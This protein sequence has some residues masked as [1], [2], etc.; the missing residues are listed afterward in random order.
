MVDFGPDEAVVVVAA[1][2]SFAAGC[3]VVVV[4]ADGGDFVVAAEEV[5]SAIDELLAGVAVHFEVAT[6]HSYH[7][8]YYWNAVDSR[9]FPLLPESCL[10]PDFCCYSR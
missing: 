6:L 10:D 9:F 3:T 1:V 4:A 8:Y 5:A 7:F 2:D